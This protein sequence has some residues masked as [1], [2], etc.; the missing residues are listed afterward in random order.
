MRIRMELL[1]PFIVSSLLGASAYAQTL[2]EF[3][4]SPDAWWPGRITAGPDGN[5]WFGESTRGGM[6]RKIGR[7]TTAGSV[8]DFPIEEGH[9]VDVND[10]TAG[11]DG[12]IWFTQA[13][14]DGG[15]SAVNRMTPTGVLT[16]FP[17]APVF[18]GPFPSFTGP[19]GITAGPDGNL[20]VTLNEV[21]SIAQ[22]TPRGELSISM[23][24]CSFQLRV[25][26]IGS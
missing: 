10:I 23:L 5:L 22:F 17:T 16:R 8:V 7:I 25:Q 3:P 11:P 1:L 12:N 4:L 9:V 18:P 20:W 24:M 26:P 15:H 19:F 13:D 14:I 6:P 2:T 21:N